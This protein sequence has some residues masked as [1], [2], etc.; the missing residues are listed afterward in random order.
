[1]DYIKDHPIIFVLAGIVIA[2]VLAQAIFFLIRAIK[3]AKAKGMNMS[4][5]KKTIVTSV[6]FTIAPAVSILIAI[7]SLVPKLGVAL[8]WLRLSVIGSLSYESIA[9]GRA[10]EAVGNPL[11]STATELNAQQFVTIAFVMIVGVA[12]SACKPDNGLPEVL[13]KVNGSIYKKV[14]YKDIY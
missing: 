5:V 8:P 4:V 12:V 1:M 14:E 10:S 7:I 9:A 6:L 3:R 11:S 2:A 13:F